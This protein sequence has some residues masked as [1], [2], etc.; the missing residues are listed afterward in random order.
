MRLPSIK[1]LSTV[2]ENPKLARKILE[3]TRRELDALP[4]GDARNVECWHRPKNY[5]VRMHCLD[6][7]DPGLHGVESFQRRDG[8]YVDYLNTG[9]MYADTLIY[10]GS[11][12]VVCLGDYI[13]QHA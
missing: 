8:R 1:T 4:A 7:I 6:A 11:Y 12:R 2:F 9:E 5:D 10:D 3:M 13:E